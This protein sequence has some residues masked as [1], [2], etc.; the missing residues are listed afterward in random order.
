MMYSA[1]NMRPYLMADKRLS[2]SYWFLAI[3]FFNVILPT[4]L[5]QPGNITDTFWHR[6]RSAKSQSI[7]V[8]KNPMAI[9]RLREL[10]RER[11][12]RARVSAQE[13][14]HKLAQTFKKPTEVVTTEG[15]ENVPSN[16]LMGLS[17][18]G[19]LDPIYKH[20]TFP[21]IEL[22]TVHTGARQRSGGMALF[23][24]TFVGKLYVRFA[25]DK[26]GFQEGVVEAFWT[27]VTE[28]VDE[29]LLLSPVNLRCRL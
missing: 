28:A 16:A 24:H 7:R 26:N 2:D 1:L 13:D 27:Q 10:A 19:N 22:H 12:A 8:V 14:D 4:F 20:S 5:P 6:A 3:G 15:N 9:S 18:L 21:E 25:Y 17:L 29:F 11:G 23:G